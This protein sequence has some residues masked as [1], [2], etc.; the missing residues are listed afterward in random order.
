MQLHI[1]IEH[2]FSY[3]FIVIISQIRS[4]GAKT[5]EFSFYNIWWQKIHI[6]P[7]FGFHFVPNF[8]WETLVLC[9]PHNKLQFCFVIAKG[10]LYATVTLRKIR[11]LCLHAQIM[12]GQMFLPLILEYIGLLTI[13]VNEKRYFAEIVCVPRHKQSNPWNS[14]CYK[15]PKK[16]L[17]ERNR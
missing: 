7:Y 11:L 2:T 10:H 6:Q 17:E 12:Y 5:Q 8:V 9:H 4:F 14:L 15:Q 16:K 3:I 1:L 13:I